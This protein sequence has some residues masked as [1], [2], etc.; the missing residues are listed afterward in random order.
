VPE[1][2]TLD[3]IQAFID[4]KTKTI[5]ACL[6]IAVAYICPCVEAQLLDQSSF[7]HK[8][9]ALLDYK[10]VVGMEESHHLSVDFTNV[11]SQTV[12]ALYAKLSGLDLNTDSYAR[13]I[14]KLISVQAYEITQTQMI[15]L[16]ETGLKEQAGIVITRIDDKRALVTHDNPQLVTKPK[17]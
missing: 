3:H 10:M 7:P 8:D 5:V 2:W 13:D 4:M 11:D 9:Y 6:I 12:I 17:D 1:L 14:H 16:V 15:K